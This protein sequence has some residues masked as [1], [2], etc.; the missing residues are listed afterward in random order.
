MAIT[1][2]VTAL[3]ILINTGVTGEQLV[4]LSDYNQL[5]SLFDSNPDLEGQLKAKLLSQYQI[6]S[7]EI[8]QNF[9][10]D[11]AESKFIDLRSIQSWMACMQQYML[12]VAPQYRQFKAAIEAARNSS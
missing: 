3:G 12:H 10:D 9:D 2:E 1:F 8:I 6:F 11:S 5:F 7:N 4:S